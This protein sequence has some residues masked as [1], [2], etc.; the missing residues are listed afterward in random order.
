MNVEPITVNLI[1]RFSRQTIECDKIALKSIEDMEPGDDV[2][3]AEW[4]AR[5]IASMRSEITTQ[6]KILDKLETR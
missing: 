1:I 5:A 4:R 3:W 2:S 6:E